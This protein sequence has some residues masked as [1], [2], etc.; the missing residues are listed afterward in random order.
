MLGCTVLLLSSRRLQPVSHSR[1]CWSCMLPPSLPPLTVLEL[2]FLSDPPLMFWHAAAALGQTYWLLPV[3]QAHWLV[4]EMQVWG[5]GGGMG[6][7]VWA[8]HEVGSFPS[9]RTAHCLLWPYS[10]AE[11][12]PPAPD[13]P[14]A[15][16][17]CLWA[18]CWTSWPLPCALSPPP[19]HAPPAPTLPL[20]TAPSAAPLAAP[21][22]MHSCRAQL[23]ASLAHPAA[24]PA[25]PVLLPAARALLAPTAVQTA[26]SAS[27]APLARTP[28]CQAPGSLHSACPLT[29]AGAARRTKPSTCRCSAS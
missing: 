17:R 16:C 21:A 15:H 23:R 2:G 22:A 9:C 29:S 3:P 8:G 13:P 24:L 10:K 6:P 19:T 11:R 20:R 12:P 5:W 1:K 27:A 18:R 7:V 4:E 26:V 25:L 14:P 28:P